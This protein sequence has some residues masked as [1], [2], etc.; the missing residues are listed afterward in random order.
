M[1]QFKARK[2]DIA[3][4][5]IEMQKK[6]RERMSKVKYKIAVMSGKGGVGKTTVAS[7]LAFALANKKYKV[8][9]LDADIYGPDVPIAVGV[10]EKFPMVMNG[11]IVPFKGPLDVRV[12]SIQFLLEKD[13]QPV[14]W[15]GPLVGKVIQQFLSDVAWEELDF[16]IIDLPPGTGDEALTVM[17]NIPDL[18]G[19]V[20]VVT[21]QK[22]ALH[23]AKKAVNM[24]KVV[25]VPVLGV[26]ENMSGF[27][28]PHCGKITYI[29][30]KGGGEEAA[31]ELGIPF[32][33]ALPLDPRVVEMTDEGKP[34]VSD[35]GNEVAKKFDE[36]VNK[37]LNVIEN[38][39]KSSAQG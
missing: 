11:V 29:F 9:I 34:I 35:M 5:I 31:K 8:G 30:G 2:E 36:I 27:R 7:N 26:I 4:Q 20:V 1:A 15:R 13:D 6:I 32:L 25:G 22:I 12:M 18:T 17:Q 33:G 3:A 14:I 21:P 37:L 39:G 38:I 16:L 23:D 28:C 10:K 24:A 19:I